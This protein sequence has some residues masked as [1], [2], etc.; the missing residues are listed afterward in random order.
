MLQVP[1]GRGDSLAALD[2]VTW[3]FFPLFYAPLVGGVMF[4]MVMLIYYFIK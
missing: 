2:S 3:L 1:E 4:A